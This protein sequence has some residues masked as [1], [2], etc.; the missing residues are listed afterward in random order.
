VKIRQ[1]VLNSAQ[2]LLTEVATDVEI[3]GNLHAAVQN[4][5]KPA[6]QHKFHVVVVQALEQVA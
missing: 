6:D 3:L 5:G 4:C 2:I 1:G